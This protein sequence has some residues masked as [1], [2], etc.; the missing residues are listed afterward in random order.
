VKAGAALALRNPAARYI[1]RTACV[2]SAYVRLPI[3]VTCGVVLLLPAPA[4]AVL[5]YQ[6]GPFDKYDA[7]IVVARDDGSHPRVVGRGYAPQV[8]ATGKRLSYFKGGALASERLYEVD[9]NG[10]HRRKLADELT[11]KYPPRGAAWSSDDRYIVV[12]GSDG[13]VRVVDRL[14]HKTYVRRVAYFA[15][16]TFEPDGDRFAVEAGSSVGSGIFVGSTKKEAMRD[17]GSGF[18]PAWGRPGLAFGRDNDIYLRRQIGKR[19]TVLLPNTGGIP[20]DWSENGHRLLISERAPNGG[21]RPAVIGLESKK[22]TRI[23][24]SVFYVDDFSDDGHDVLVEKDGN[25]VRLKLDGTKRLL[26]E[27][28][29]NAT[30]SK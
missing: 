25:L 14:R 23:P 5:V 6:R 2:F 8:S 27:N 28:A 4:G 21:V 10:Q 30:W 18:R 19:A 15:D 3:F 1:V 29:S 17:Q 7:P 9:V 11:G 12:S 22:V 16:A 26:V 24:V 20:V 13:G